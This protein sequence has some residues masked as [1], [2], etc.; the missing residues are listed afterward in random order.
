MENRKTIILTVSISITFD[1]NNINNDFIQS[2]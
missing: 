1:T 2:T